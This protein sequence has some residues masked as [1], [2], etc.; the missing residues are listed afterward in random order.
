MRV[1]D[2]S[3]TANGMVRPCSG[4]ASKGQGGGDGLSVAGLAVLESSTRQDKGSRALTCEGASV[5]T[6]KGSLWPSR[7]LVQGLSV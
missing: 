1:F 7:A 2:P 5:V 4:P 3:M 6:T